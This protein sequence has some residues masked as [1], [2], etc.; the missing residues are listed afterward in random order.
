MFARRHHGAVYGQGVGMQGSSYA[1]PTKDDYLQ[2]LSVAAIA[3]HV[4]D[5]LAFARSRPDLTFRVT[6][7]G[8]GLAGLSPAQIGPLFRGHPDNC[9]M[10]AEFRPFTEEVAGGDPG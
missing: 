1:I 7:V 10:P 9:V 3:G 8:C 6:A 5:F 2:T 4:A